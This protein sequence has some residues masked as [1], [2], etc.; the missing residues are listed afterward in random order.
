MERA[1]LRSE[2]ATNV[3]RL[4]QVFQVREGARSRAGILAVAIVGGA[5]LA[6]TGLASATGSSSSGTRAGSVDA[7]AVDPENTAT[8]YASSWLRSPHYGS[9]LKSTNGGRSWRRIYA[10]A[11][12][13]ILAFAIDPRVPSVLY[14]GTTR[15]LIPTEAGV[16]KS[17]DGGETWRAA[18]DGLRRNPVSSLAIDPQEPATLYTGTDR[19]GFGGWGSR[20]VFKTTNGGRTWKAVNAGR[21]TLADDVNALAINPVRPA[22]LYA[23]AVED[24]LFKTT[25][26]GRSWRKVFDYYN[27]LV[28]SLAID[29]KKPTTVYAGTF[30]DGVFKTIDGGRS[31]RVVNNGLGNFKDVE[32]LA[33]DPRNTATIYAATH[34]LDSGGESVFRSG[35]VFKSTDGGRSWRE[36]N[37]GLATAAYGVNTFAIDP[38]APTTVYAGTTGYGVFK[39]ID[40][41]RNWRSAG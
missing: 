20:G 34:R 40:G 17:V 28:T 38:R 16:F 32:A 27:G 31:W 2:T 14:L 7:L 41:G 9:I 3:V 35:R 13:P 12:N 1:D 29:P 36:A 30:S 8:V 11:G 23:A 15:Y 26:G 39:T 10:G 21:G 18:N 33:I 5:A 4:Y 6:S 25:N 37:A 19:Y 24:G 22:I